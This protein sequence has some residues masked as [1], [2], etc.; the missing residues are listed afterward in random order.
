MG[1]LGVKDSL[2]ENLMQSKDTSDS[3]SPRYA[4]PA[5]FERTYRL[6]EKLGEG[7]FSVVRLGVNKQ[8]QQKVAVKIVNKRGI[9]QDEV[10]AIKGVRVHR[11]DVDY[12]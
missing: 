3:S 9:S 4:G 8:T 12:C 1:N 6:G 7:A 11:A 10:V 5:S 2:Q